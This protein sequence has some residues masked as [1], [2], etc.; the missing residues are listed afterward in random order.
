M[1]A[2]RR[3]LHRRQQPYPLAWQALRQAR[4]R[5]RGEG[6]ETGI[7]ADGLAV[8]EQDDRLAVRRHLHRAQGDA[9]GDHRLLPAFQARAEQTYAHAVGA[10][11]HLPVAVERIEQAHG[12][13]VADL[14]AEDQLQARFAGAVHDPFAGHRQRAWPCAIGQPAEAVACGQGLAVGAGA[15]QAFAGHRGQAAQLALAGEAAGRPQVGAGPLA[16]LV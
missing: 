2:V 5:Q 16:G 6:A 13:E 14:R 15:A 11:I 4:Q 7:A 9:F 10:G 3:L 8:V 12:R 1:L